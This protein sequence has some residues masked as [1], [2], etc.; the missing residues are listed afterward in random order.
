MKER[1]EKTSRMYPVR[2]CKV[3]YTLVRTRITSEKQN[4]GLFSVRVENLTDRSLESNLDIEDLSWV[5]DA[6]CI[7]PRTITQ[8]IASLT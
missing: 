7:V 1:R 8:L 5:G 3:V 2:T 4:S 6:A